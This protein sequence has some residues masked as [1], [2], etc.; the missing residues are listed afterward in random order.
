M[1]WYAYEY[2]ICPKC[3]YELKKEVSTLEMAKG[4]RSKCPKCNCETK[5]IDKINKKNNF[6]EQINKIF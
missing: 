3:G 5:V 2:R 1:C 6:L 4:N